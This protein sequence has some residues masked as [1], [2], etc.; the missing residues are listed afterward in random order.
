M[1]RS[2]DLLIG[3]GVA[4]AFTFI[5]NLP[6]WHAIVFT[7]ELR[8]PDVVLE[9]NDE[10]FYLARINEVADGHWQMGHP[11]VYEHR[12]ERYGM[13]NGSELLLGTVMRI[14][15]LSIKAMSLAG[16]LIFPFILVLLAWLASRYHLP[17]W[18]LRTLF[19]ACIFLGPFISLWKRPIIP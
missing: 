1:N 4:A 14:T 17:D 13:G 19:L 15:G 11:Y 16:D 6:L 7:D 12:N 10:A 18:R 8:H 5:I 9:N 3:L 2:K